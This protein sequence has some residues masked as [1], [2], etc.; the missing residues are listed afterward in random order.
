MH[1]QPFANLNQPAIPLT[2]QPFALL[3]VMVKIVVQ[4]GYV[5]EPSH[6]TLGQLDKKTEVPNAGDDRIECVE[7]AGRQLVLEIF[8]LL[9]F[10]G[11]LLCF[12]SD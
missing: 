9:Q 5:N 11:L 6:E 8:D 7:L 3:V 1:A 12:I 2:D 4:G 10:D